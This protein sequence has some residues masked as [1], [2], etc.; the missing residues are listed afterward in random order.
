MA[1]GHGHLLPR[2]L[3]QL[4]E[5]RGEAKELL[6]GWGKCG[7]TF[8]SNEERSSK[9]LLKQAHACADCCL[10]DMQ[11]IGRFNEASGRDDLQ[12]GPGELNVHV[13]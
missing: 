7:T 5:S 2:A 8:I 13:S 11:P 1:F 9:L 6:A 10:G 12:K 4:H 3:P